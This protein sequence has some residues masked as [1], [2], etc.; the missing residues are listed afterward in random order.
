MSRLPSNPFYP[1]VALLGGAFIVTILALAASIAGDPES[2]ANRF[3][4]KHG[5]RLILAEVAG[6]LV[7]GFLALAVDRR[8]MRRRETHPAETTP[9]EDHSAENGGFSC[10]KHAGPDA[11]EA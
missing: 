9:E 5:G 7:T 11:P 2:P 6:I 3:L 10:P 8:Q 1:G 4:D